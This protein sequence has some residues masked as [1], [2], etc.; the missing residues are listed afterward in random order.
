MADG[1]NDPVT[2]HFVAGHGATR[3][4]I[5]NSPNTAYAVRQRF[6]D[7]LAK[8][9]DE[10]D[11]GDW[12]RTFAEKNPKAFAD[13]LSRT[14]P[15][16]SHE[17]KDINITDSRDQLELVRLLDGMKAGLLPGPEKLPAEIIEGR[18]IED[19]RG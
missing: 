1:L 5:P 4:G 11:R 17:T 7:A 2:G 12:V 10:D 19:E 9:D 6:W 8:L 18:V 15:K 13:I 3:K 14:F 16:E